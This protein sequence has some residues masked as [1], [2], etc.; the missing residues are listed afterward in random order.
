MGADHEQREQYAE[1]HHEGTQIA[2]TDFDGS[3]FFV[4][5]R[6]QENIEK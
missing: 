3:C 6:L 1:M 2:G 4:L 5:D